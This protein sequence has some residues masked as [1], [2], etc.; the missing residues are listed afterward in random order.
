MKRFLSMA[1]HKVAPLVAILGLLI[2]P[3]LPL[4]ASA[5]AVNNP[6][7][8]A[9]ISFT[10]D[11]GL[12]SAATQAAP[13]L[14]QH[15]LTG[16]DYVITD[17]VGMTQVPNTCRA[18]TSRSYMTWAQVQSLQNTSG[19]EIGS[20]TVDHKCLASNRSQDPGDCQLNTLTVAQ[21]DSELASSKSVLSANGINATDFA[22]PYGDYNNSVLAE[23]AKYYA[24]MRNF[25]NDAADPNIWPYSDYYLWDYV[26]KEGTTPVSAVE[27][28]VDKAIANKQWL[29]LSFHDITPSPSTNPEDYQ[30][31]TGEL[32][33]IAAYV[34]AKQTAGLIR[35]QHVNQELVTSDTNLLPNA[36]FN[37]GV[38]DGWTTD[39][40]T[41]VVK[42]TANNGSYPDPTNAIRLTSPAGGANAHLFSPKVAV[43]PYA[44]YLFK[45]FLNVQTLTSGQVAFYVDEYDANG[46]WI[47]GQYLEQENSPFVESMN[48]TYK[49]S[50]VAVSK[51]SLQTIVG[52]SGITAFVDNSQAFP[53]ATASQTNLVSNGTFNAGIASDWATDAPNTIKAD[54]GNNGSPANPVN[55]VAMT[56]TAVNTHLFSPKVSVSSANN[57][58]VNAYLNL[59]AIT[60]NEVGFYVDEYD[61]NGN[62]MSGRYIPGVRSVGAGNFGFVYTPSSLN[63]KSASLQVIVTG[64][65]NASAY[66]D[67]VKWYQS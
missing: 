48:F 3:I 67:D 51:A 44:T 20:H 66:F 25:R 39:N 37:D 53:V 1:V 33:Q 22:P 61:A 13:T 11:D 50:S 5:L 36:S 59:K 34:Q 9:T 7:P 52:G 28:A 2:A 49:P 63:V 57:Y 6:A 23:I 58:N 8:A 46:N 16:T 29:V 54:A 18:N 38:A 14:A 15:G 30:Y 17:C 27:S 21:V 42:D 31:G 24:S 32:D 12:A 4:R 62:W 65:S 56:A 35:S 47:S 19:W 64:S 40:A 41:A 10:F 60:A 55:S 45:D 26:V 43:D